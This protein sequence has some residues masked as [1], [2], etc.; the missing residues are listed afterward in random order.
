MDHYDNAEEEKDSN[1]DLST[2]FAKDE[3]KEWKPT[4][5]IKNRFSP[6]FVEMHLK[7]LP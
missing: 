4:R 7:L 3:Q 2:E 5:K 1:K 6:I